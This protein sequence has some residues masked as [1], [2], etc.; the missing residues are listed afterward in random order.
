[1]IGELAYELL[2]AFATAV[3]VREAFR[4]LLPRGVRIEGVRVVP[5]D[6]GGPGVL[7]DWSEP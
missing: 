6:Y 2:V 4:G 7:I 1:M 3:L 5:C